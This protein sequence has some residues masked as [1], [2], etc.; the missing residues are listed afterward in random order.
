MNAFLLNIFLALIWASAT[1]NFAESNL[2]FGFVLGFAI[3]AFTQQASGSGDYARRGWRVFS[4]I[5]FFIK[6]LVLANIR[7]AR[8]VISRSHNMRPGVVA[9]PLSAKTDIEITFLANVISLTPGTLSLDVSDDR[10]VLYIH[11]MYVD[12]PDEL[13]HEIKAGFERRI[14]EVL[15]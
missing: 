10:T 13:R 5:G 4:F 3:I 14:L 1:G 12:D 11:S 8:D 9:I 7:V 2:V 6:E 15:R